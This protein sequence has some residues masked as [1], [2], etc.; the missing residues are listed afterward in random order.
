MS[1]ENALK[2][3]SKFGMNRWAK[4]ATDKVMSDGKK[5]TISEII[6][7]LWEEVESSKTKRTGMNMPTRGELRSHL[8]NYES[9]QFDIYTGS[10]RSKSTG[11]TV[12]KWWKE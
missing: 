9:G 7:K 5:R 2:K 1:W 8:R 12:T 3:R 6:G 11:N 10:E 4:E